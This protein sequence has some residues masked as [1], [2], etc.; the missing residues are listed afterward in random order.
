MRVQFSSSQSPAVA[1]RVPA[2]S[3]ARILSARVQCERQVDH[4]HVTIFVSRE[5]YDVEVDAAGV[6]YR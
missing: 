3:P 4:D 2:E 5:V 1:A 6:Y